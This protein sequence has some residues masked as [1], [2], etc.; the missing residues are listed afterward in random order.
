M[1][2]E[3]IQELQRCNE[4]LKRRKFELELALAAAIHDDEENLEVAKIKLRVVHP[5]SGIDSMLDVLKCL[6][7]TGTKTKAIQSTFSSQEFSAVLQIE[8]KIGLQLWSF[9]V[10]DKLSRTLFFCIARH[11]SATVLVVINISFS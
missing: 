3:R 10:Y 2:A 4:E 9:P 1:A 5:S 11:I 7:N 6:K 8:T